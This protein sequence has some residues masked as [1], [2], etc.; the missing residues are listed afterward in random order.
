M[1]RKWARV[2]IYLLKRKSKRKV[3]SQ[4][5]VCMWTDV[6]EMERYCRAGWWFSVPF[7]MDWHFTLIDME[8]ERNVTTGALP[9]CQPFLSPSIYFFLFQ[10]HCLFSSSILISFLSWS[11]KIP[12]FCSL[13]CLIPLLCPYSSS[14]VWCISSHFIPSTPSFLLLFPS[15]SGHCACSS[16]SPSA[17]CIPAV[18]GK[19]SL[20]PTSRLK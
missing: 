14:Y 19:P 15:L 13:L 4:M 6:C 9:L 16:C 20:S 17:P 12:S 5:L 11:L 10:S 8:S 2:D 18:I 1:V 7:I 3:M